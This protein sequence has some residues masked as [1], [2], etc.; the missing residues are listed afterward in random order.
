MTPPNKA[1]GVWMCSGCRHLHRGCDLEGTFGDTTPGGG[2][3]LSRCDELRT[4]GGN[5]SMSPSPS[6]PTEHRDSDSPQRLGHAAD[7]PEPRSPY[8]HPCPRM[9]L[10]RCCHRP[11]GARRTRVG[12]G[13][14]G[15]PGKG[16]RGWGLT[17]PDTP[18]RGLGE[19]GYPLRDRIEPRRV[20]GCCQG[21]GNPLRHPP[22][23]RSPFSPRSR[24]TGRAAP[25]YKHR[26]RQ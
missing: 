15:D 24:F 4:D 25:V 12:P 13:V 11:A 3:G 23:S 2:G 5:A 21:G 14:G 7:A 9:A 16:C 10:G 18:H 17:A 1:L 19:L 8:P 22:Y 6:P 26:Q 20:G